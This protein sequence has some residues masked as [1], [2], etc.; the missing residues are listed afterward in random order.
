MYIITDINNTQKYLGIIYDNQEKQRNILFVGIKYCTFRGIEP[1]NSYW[2]RRTLK[3]LKQI[4][5]WEP[6]V[7]WNRFC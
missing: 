6:S 4:P 3:R 1:T 2:Y 5:Y 7:G